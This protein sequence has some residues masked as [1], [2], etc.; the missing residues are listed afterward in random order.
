MAE[1]RVILQ[2]GA[3]KTTGQRMTP[4][5]DAGPA[6]P[7]GPAGRPGTMTIKIRR[8][9]RQ[10]SGPL[11]ILAAALFAAGVISGLFSYLDRSSVRE[12]F[13][14]G[15]P[16]WWQQAVY[17]GRSARCFPVAGLGRLTG[18]PAAWVVARGLPGSV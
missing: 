3:A 16:A 10:L 2:T 8:V 7:G 5:Q 15:S 18:R 1:S 14:P 9:A 6:R 12:R 17:L 13:I 11:V 4:G